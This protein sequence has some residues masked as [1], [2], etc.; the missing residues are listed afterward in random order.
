MRAFRPGS[1]ADRTSAAR[2]ASGASWRIAAGGAHRARGGGVDAPAALTSARCRRPSPGRRPAPH[3]RRACR[4][5]PPAGAPRRCRCAR[6]AAACRA[7][8]R[9]AHPESGSWRRARRCADLAG[10]EEV[11]TGTPGAALGQ[12]HGGQ[13]ASATAPAAAFRCAP[14]AAA[15][16]HQRLSS[17]SDRS[18]PV[19]KWRPSARST[20]VCS[21]VSAWPLH[22]GQQRL[23]QVRPQR[24]AALGPRQRQR[25]HAVAAN[26]A[27]HAP[28]RTAAER[29]HR[30][31][32]TALS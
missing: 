1:A 11:G 27:H 15:S 16:R 14:G 20:S 7:R 4:R 18:S 8:C 23:D 32:S 10:G 22:R 6:P 31:G 2:S 12:R 3:R 30:L 19:Q 29:S 24:V 13:R 25:Q 9:T 28:L 5:R 17:R 26:A 21:V